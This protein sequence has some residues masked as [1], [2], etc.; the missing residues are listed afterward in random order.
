MRPF[1]HLLLPLLSLLAALALVGGA[2]S[3]GS[4]LT[5]NSARAS[6]TDNPIDSGL[7]DVVAALDHG[8]GDDQGGDDGSGEDNSGSG[9]SNSGSGSGD[10]GYGDSKSGDDSN[11]GSGSDSKSDDAKGDNNG[12]R[13]KDDPRDHDNGSGNDYKLDA[14]AAP[15]P[16]HTL[17]A[18]PEGKVY[19]KLPGRSHS[20]LLPD[21]GASLPVGTIIDARAGVVNVT[22][23]PGVDRKPQHSDFAGGAFQIRQATRR[24]PITDLFM[25]GGDFSQCRAAA[26]GRTAGASASRRRVVRRLWGSG[27]GRFRT[28]GRFSAASVR[29]TI[30]M[31]EDRCDGTLIAVKR[32]KVLVRDKVRHRYIYVR[33]GQ[34]YLARAPRGTS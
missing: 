18:D 28:H 13:V 22:T 16:G 14:P 6:S 27:H 24:H 30:W 11:K 5:L 23:A 2:G 20:V 32:G 21:R 25:R 15:K 12:D 33:S 9:S 34:H 1:R 7:A 29:G 31:T 17:N 3:F 26:T 8:S 4:A 19:V 10:S